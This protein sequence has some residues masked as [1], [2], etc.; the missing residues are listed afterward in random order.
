M[1]ADITCQH[2][3]VHEEVFVGVSGSKV[4]E[5]SLS[6]Y[7]SNCSTCPNTRQQTEGL[8]FREFVPTRELETNLRSFASPSL[9]SSCRQQPF[10][11][12][13]GGPGCWPG[14]IQ[15]CELL[16]LLFILLLGIS[17]IAGE[18]GVSGN[19]FSKGGYETVWHADLFPLRGPG[20][21]YTS[22]CMNG[23][24]RQCVSLGRGG[25]SKRVYVLRS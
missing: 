8:N 19:L 5:H 20:P 2:L 12:G 6:S 25:E 3:C 16:C 17:Q 18:R 23:C 14:P 15:L 7:Y 13:W 24:M 4:I 10:S 11:R 9:H 22:E 1:N 21:L